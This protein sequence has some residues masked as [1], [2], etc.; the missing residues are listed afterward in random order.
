MIDPSALP[1][2]TAPVEHHADFV[3]L[4]I[5]RSRHQRM[6]IASYMRVLD[7]AAA[8]EILADSEDEPLGQWM[9]TAAESLAES[10]FAEL[11]ERFN[12]CGKDAECYPFELGADSVA[13]R[14]NAADSVYT[15]LALLSWFGKDAGPRDLDGEK[16]FE[17]VCAMACKS[18]L[19]WPHPNV[20]SAVFGF[21]RRLAPR[22]FADAVDELCRALGEGRG[23]HKNRRLVRTQKD[24]KLD[25]VAW[26]E[27]SDHREGKV[28]LFGQCA[29][30]Q[31][32]RNKMTELPPPVDWCRYW[33]LDA[34]AVSPIRCFFV[35][36]RIERQRWVHACL[37]GGIVFD[38]CRIAGLAQRAS[39]EL[40]AEWTA[41][42]RH[43]LGRLREW[44]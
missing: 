30:G 4:D 41:W 19:G 17:E 20:R 5:L 40:K 44:S 1:A 15:F 9:D 2:A 6:S 24:A 32:W 43:V 18:Y 12:A 21:P 34:P 33:M 10:V 31:D 36:H 3:E 13:A 39:S 7:S 29:T 16:L 28:I 11:D 25:V 42:S 37:L 22:G 23:C 26:R 27:F 8:S 38:R 14:T 35:P